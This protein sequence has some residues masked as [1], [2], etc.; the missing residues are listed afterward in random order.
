MDLLDRS[1]GIEVV[2]DPRPAYDVERIRREAEPLGIH[3]KELR[4][5]ARGHRLL[6]RLAYTHPAQIDADNL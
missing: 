6:R 1:L 4:F 2:E 3:L 5:E